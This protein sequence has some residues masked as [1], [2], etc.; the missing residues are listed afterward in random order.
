MSAW[1][2]IYLV[3]LLVP[4]SA[5]FAWSAR[6]YFRHRERRR[7]DHRPIS[8]IRS[9][10]TLPLDVRLAVLEAQF[11]VAP[12]LALREARASLGYATS[13]HDA[14]FVPARTTREEF[15]DILSRLV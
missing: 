6:D 10:P 7:R 3:V 1:V 11:I 8:L 2:A 14:Q 13:S 9:D 15:D 5:L 4:V 12:E